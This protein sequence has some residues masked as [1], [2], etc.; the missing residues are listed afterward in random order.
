M[1][2]PDLLEDQKEHKGHETIHLLGFH[3]TEFSGKILIG[4]QMNSRE[5]R[6]KEK[7]LCKLRLLQEHFVLAGIISVL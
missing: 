7:S 3:P 6:K 2:Y 4:I 1:I 5:K